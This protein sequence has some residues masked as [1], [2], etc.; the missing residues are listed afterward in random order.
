MLHCFAG[1]TV[2]ADVG[3]YVQC[4]T[5]AIFHSR[6]NFLLFKKSEIMHL[7]APYR[8]MQR[9]STCLLWCV[10]QR[11]QTPL[12]CSCTQQERIAA[13]QPRLASQLVRDLSSNITGGEEAPPSTLPKLVEALS[14]ISTQTLDAG[15]HLVPTPIGEWQQR[16]TLLLLL[17]RS[18]CTILKLFK[19]PLHACRVTCILAAQATERISLCALC[20][21]SAS[22][23]LSMRRIRDTPRI[24]CHT[25]ASPLHLSAC[26]STT[27][28]AA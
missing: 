11:Q 21:C 24:Y 7:S 18:C 3:R 16:I 9:S 20:A 1:A 12:S 13:P 8:H 25:T 28:I 17:S 6:S 26:M 22:S 19:I 4:R 23:A 10:V 5:L 2:A 14:V 27:S 15:L